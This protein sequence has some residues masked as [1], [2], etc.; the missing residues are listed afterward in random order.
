MKYASVLIEKG[1][2][3]TQSYDKTPATTVK[4]PKQRDN[5][6]IKRGFYKDVYTILI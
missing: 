2:D 4:S 1:R 3:L 6:N 5:T